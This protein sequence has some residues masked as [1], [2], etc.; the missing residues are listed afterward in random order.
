MSDATRSAFPAFE[1]V[2]SA[3]TYSI[4]RSH[5]G[6]GFSP[7]HNPVARFVVEQCARAPD[8]LRLPLRLATRLFDLSAIPL[9]GHRFHRLAHDRRQRHIAAWVR[10]PFA[11]CRDLM[12]FYESLVVFEWT[13]ARDEDA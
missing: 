10:V 9:T 6:P 7:F 5:G 3:L 11:A 8:H 1:D 2:V 4:I 12:R 13:S